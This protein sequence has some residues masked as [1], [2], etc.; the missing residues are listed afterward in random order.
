[1]V[2]GSDI[3]AVGDIDMKADGD[4]AVI[5]ADEM[6][7]LI[8]TNGECDEYDNDVHRECVGGYGEVG[9]E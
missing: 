2:V 8:D 1:M 5:S 6:E 3:V 4:M 9:E 7:E